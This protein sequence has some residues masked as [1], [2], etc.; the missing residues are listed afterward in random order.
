MAQ[1]VIRR[2]A[3]LAPVVF[4]VSVIIFVAMR[5]MPGD[6]ALAVTGGPGQSPVT[7][8]ELDTIRQ[9][10]GLNRPLHEQYTS[11]MA[12]LLRLDAGRSFYTGKPVLEEIGRRIPVTVNLAL[13]A[14]F[15][16]V[17]IGVPLGVL[18]AVY[19]GKA[20]DYGVRLL[21]VGGL[22][23]PTFW[24]GTLILLVLV[25]W[26]NWFPPLG[27]IPVHENPLANLQQLVWPALAIGYYSSAYLS[28]MTRSCVL[29]VLQQD[30]VRAAWAKGLHHRVVLWRH[31]M[32]NAM[33][34]VV[35]LMGMQFAFLL[36]GSVVIENI[37]GLP[38]IGNALV[39][40]I[41]NRDY[42]MVQT[43]IVLFSVTLVL[44]NLLIDVLYGW[45]DPRVRY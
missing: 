9:E 44:I 38:G 14:L 34:P 16:A 5:I 30:Y 32:K 35:T 13:F 4:G 12:G 25:V 1:Y 21:A 26:F 37:F 8:R 15:I 31:V 2:L 17:A 22:A 10:L 24:T 27:F 7:Q 36:E 20:F 23:L 40:S 45:L 33:L 43:L 6:V 18:S 29:E 39:N 19:R 28:R 3:L 11:W 41:H 42:P